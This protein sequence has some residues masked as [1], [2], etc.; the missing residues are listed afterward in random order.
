MSDSKSG[1]APR[2]DVITYDDI[3]SVTGAPLSDIDP[4]DR[5][6]ARRGAAI[7]ADALRAEGVDCLFGYP[8]GANLE[9]FDVLEPS[10]IRC[11][12]TEH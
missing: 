12:R 10:G 2:G 5:A 3:A 11:Y 9:I 1:T 7:L 6:Q 4:A 8:G